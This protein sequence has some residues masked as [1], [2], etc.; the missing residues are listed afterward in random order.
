[1]SFRRCQPWEPCPSRR[2][3]AWRSAVGLWAALILILPASNLPAAANAP[4][5]IDRVGLGIN[6][7]YKLGQW[8]TVRIDV[9]TLDE[10]FRGRLVVQ[11]PDANGVA[12]D[13]IRDDLVVPAATSQSCMSYIK[14]GQASGDLLVRL[15]HVHGGHVSRRLGSSERPAPLPTAQQLVIALGDNL[16]VDPTRSFRP[17]ATWV[18]CSGDRTIELPRHWLGYSS[19]DAIVL[20]TSRE[21]ELA[22]IDAVQWEALRNWV[23]LGGRVIVC[24]A[25]RATELFGS[26]RPLAWLVPGEVRGMLQQRQTSGIEQF[27]EATKRLDHMAA[28]G[29]RFSIPMAQVRHPRGR[30]EAAEGFGSDQSAALIR[31]SAGLGRVVFV[32]FDLDQAPFS[33]WP[34]RPLLLAKL[35]NFVLD[36]S[37][38]DEVF[39]SALGPV[40]HVGYSDLVGQLRYALDQF[41][42]VQLVPFSWIAFL[43]ATYILIVG[44]LDYWLLTR[45]G[46]PEW[47]WLTFGLTVMAFTLLA[48]VLAARWK[49]DAY[50]C[51]Q[52]T[53]IDVDLPSGQVRGTTWAHVFSPRTRTVNLQTQPQAPFEWTSPPHQVTSWHGLPGDGFG[54]LDRRE[55]MKTFKRPYQSP[56]KLGD[57]TAADVRLEQ[58]PIAIW[59]SQSLLGQW[60]GSAQWPTGSAQLSAGADATLSGRIANPLPV[61]LDDVYLVYHRVAFRLGKLKRGALVQVDGAVEIDLQSLLTQRTVVEGRNIMTP[62]NQSSADVDRIMQLLTFYGAAKGRAYTRLQHRYQRAIDWSDHVTANHAVLWGRASELGAN[63]LL[64]GQ[65]IRATEDRTYYRLLIP[66]SRP[67]E[68]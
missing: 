18:D 11:A 2:P 48:V 5:A 41:S 6:G 63:L 57:G 22:R 40:A 1:V 67:G 32:P 13:Y 45:W 55:P 31:G 43:M 66:V 56:L 12:V 64:D 54:G 21:G 68:A 44:P 14:L 39:Q 26:D 9:R 23:E 33:T 30:V 10:P 59:S 7:A 20:A 17:Q 25:V 8:T 52:V 49:G 27:A 29:L 60:W 35:M 38:D 15:E 61:D 16:G 3:L 42:G 28:D 46:R 24:G 65:P 34:D 19:V 37:E 51:N 58:F 62:W 50:R 47:T 36:D 4:A 53:L